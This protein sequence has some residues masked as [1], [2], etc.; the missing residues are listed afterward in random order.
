MKRCCDQVRDGLGLARTGRPLDDEVAAAQRI[1]EG[2]CLGP[3]CSVDE[4]KVQ[5]NYLRYRALVERG[6]VQIPGRG[7]FTLSKE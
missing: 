7:V 4:A 2:L 3:I 6:M 5:V 1:E